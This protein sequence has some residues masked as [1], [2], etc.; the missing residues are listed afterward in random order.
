MHRDSRPNPTSIAPGCALA[1][2]AKLPIAGSVKT[3]L[4]PPLAPEEAAA[5]SECFLRDM[6]MNFASLNA[7][8]TEGVVL[9]TPAN[10]KM[11][12]RELL[13]NTFK[14]V[15]QR[16]ETLGERLIN[17]ADELLSN[18]FESV[19]L[20]NSDSPTLPREILET[21]VSHLARNGDR[22]VLGPSE[23]GGYYL[24]GLKRPHRNLFERIAWSTADVLAHTIERAAE[25]NLPVELLPTW[26]DVDDSSSLRLLCDELSLSSDG[27]DIRS[28][29]RSG[30]AAPHT[31]EYLA[32]LLKENKDLHTWGKSYLR[33]RGR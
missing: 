11:L 31:R 10:S 3:R 2:M 13:P 15:A 9:Y 33:D 21:A 30:F 14:L 12:L 22:V 6:T 4:T 25:I 16:G 27:D 7:G 32:S 17:A 26:Y 18:G 5:L 28:E 1:L 8:G 29:F 24:I 20:I 23:D 19:C